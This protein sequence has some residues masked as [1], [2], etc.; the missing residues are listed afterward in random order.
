[1]SLWESSVRVVNTALVPQSQNGWI[2]AGE[3][4]AQDLESGNYVGESII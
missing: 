2:Q 3:N 1:M 4:A